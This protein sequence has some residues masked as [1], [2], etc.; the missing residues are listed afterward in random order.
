MILAAGLGTRLR[1]WT[2]EHPKAL[3]PVAGTPALERL[4]R[5]LTAEGFTRI[6]VNVHHFASQI[7][8]F[9]AATDFGV[10]ISVSDESGLL[11]DTGGGIVHARDFLCADSEPFLVHN[12]DII[13]TADLRG[14]MR[15]H[16]A[17]GRDATLLVSDRPS[18]RRLFYD[19]ATGRLRGWMD[20]R[21]G[22]TRPAGFA[23]ATEGV[24][25]CGF[26]G[27]H[28][29]SPRLVTDMH[30]CYGDRPFPIMDYYL[31]HTDSRAIGCEA[32]AFD[33]FDIGKPEKLAAAEAFLRARNAD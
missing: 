28:A 8:D 5:K 16:D 29:I 31:T 24:T 33:A 11:L 12:V 27:I 23:G 10:P 26:S 7:T 20:M 22:E 1:P 2:L 32:A 4:I 6:V 17:D 14:L 9:L 25:A 21:T 3:V 13:S 30:A 18:S 19:N 15:R